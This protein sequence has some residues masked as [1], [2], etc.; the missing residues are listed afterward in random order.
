MSR[1]DDDLNLDF[2]PIEKKKLGKWFWI[3]IGI[4]LA[5]IMIG[6]V[7]FLMIHHYQ[8]TGSQVAE[9]TKS[10]VPTKTLYVPLEEEIIVGI[11]DDAGTQHHLNIAITLVT[12]D[13]SLIKL[14]KK[15]Q[16]LIVN[17]LLALLGTQEYRLLSAPQGKVALREK[18][19]KVVKAIVKEQSGQDIVESLL[20]TK[21]VMD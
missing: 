1:Y 5:F 6:L 15:H 17:D 19:L 9:K 18:A 14:T 8:S 13:E 16:P 7:S 20:F 12:R 2:M 3:S 4:V 21:F 11:N 10:I